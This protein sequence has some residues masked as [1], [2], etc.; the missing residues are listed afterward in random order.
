M[1]DQP[2]DMQSQPRDTLD[3]PPDPRPVAFGTVF[4]V[5]QHLDRLGDVVLA[6]LG[7][8]TKQWLLLAVVQ[9]AFAGR[10]PTLTEAASAY[11]TSRQNVKAIARG[12][13]AAGYLRIV[14]DAVDRR[15]TRLAVTD[16][17]G[18]F[19]TPE[20]H[21]REEAFFAF[22]FGDLEPAEI[23]RLADLLQHWLASVASLPEPTRTLRAAPAPLADG[24]A[25][26]ERVAR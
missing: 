25:D 1:Q 13:E 8:T 21:A 26:H 16:R 3:Q 6:P 5:A 23:A 14:P 24:A 15:A 22:A 18:V 19:A 2:P 17:V 7:L 11:G 20:W 4:V 10:R 12:L 9:R